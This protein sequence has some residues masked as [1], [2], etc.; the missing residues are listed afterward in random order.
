MEKLAVIETGGKQY[1]V[2]EGDKIKVEKLPG[3]DGDAFNFEKVL[4]VADGKNVEIG[5][6][7]VSS[8][9]VSGKILRKLREKKKIV[10]RYHSKTR[11]RKLKGHRQT[12]TEVLIEKINF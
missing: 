8:A 6:P 11:Y 12:Y 10:F 9:S 2:K 7:L 4:L 1:K 3:K 5:K